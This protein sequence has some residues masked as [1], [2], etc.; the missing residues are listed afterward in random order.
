MEDP[1]VQTQTTERNESSI[2]KKE[3]LLKS[4]KKVELL[5][6]HI[7][8]MR[9]YHGSLVAGV[10]GFE[11]GDQQSIGR[12]IY[13]TLQK[14]AA[15]GYASKRSG[16]DGV[17]TVYEVQISDLDIADLRTKEAQEE[18]AKLFKQSLIEWEESVL[19]NLKGPSDEVLGVIKEQ[20]KEAVRELV[21]KIDTNTF[22][23]LRDLT[24]GWADL[25]STTLS[26]VGY[27][28]LMSIEGEPPDIDF[29][30][31]IVMF[32]PLDIRTINQEKAVPVMPPG[33]MGEY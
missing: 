22:L 31:S 5:T 20:R 3:I 7:T 25:V 14:E 18:F 23:Q 12:G 30:D 26:N 19:P 13:L 2:S 4:G 16:H 10:T 1:E 29:H 8:Q 33:R 6:L 32:N 17:P 24:F 21:H 9:L 15:S 28:G 11:E 27:K